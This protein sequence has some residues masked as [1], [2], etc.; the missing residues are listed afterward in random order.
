MRTWRGLR[1]TSSPARA[2][3]CSRRPPT[4]TAE[5][6]G[7]IWASSPRKRASAAR[8]VS[9]VRPDGSPS[10]S[11]FPSASWVSVAAPKATVA[12]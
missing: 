6:M 1:S 5:Y 9:T 3:S 7:G 4:R 8:T 12:S 2:A 10:A 11:T